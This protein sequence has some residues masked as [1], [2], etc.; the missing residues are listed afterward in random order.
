MM[1]DITLNANMK[2][3]SKN[4]KPPLEII[5][6]E[7]KDKS[8]TNEVVKSIQNNDECND[9]EKVLNTNVELKT[10]DQVYAMK[11][12]DEIIEIISIIPETKLLSATDDDVMFQSN[13]KRLLNQKVGNHISQT[14]CDR[15]C[16]TTR[17]IV[18]LYKSKEQFLTLAKPT[19]VFSMNE[20]KTVKRF[21]LKGNKQLHFFVI[22][23]VDL[24]VKTG[25]CKLLRC[26][27]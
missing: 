25:I 10:E 18:R 15:F 26:N 8:Y 9:E 2:S 5:N 1:H 19:N 4:S 16:I 14:F 6:E 27:R 23:L 12:N 20:I 17:N 22:E 24:N 13:I 21:Y 11:I 3:K 7:Q